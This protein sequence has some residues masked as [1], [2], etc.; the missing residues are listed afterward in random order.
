MSDRPVLD[1]RAAVG[2]WPYPWGNV[3]ELAAVLP[4]DQWTLIGG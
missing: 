3:A 2:G 1:V 4:G